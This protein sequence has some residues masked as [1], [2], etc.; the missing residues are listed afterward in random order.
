MTVRDYFE[1]ILIL[2]AVFVGF[3]IVI[4]VLV[5][6]IDYIEGV[7]NSRKANLYNR[8]CH[9]KVKLVANDFNQIWVNWQTCQINNT[10]SKNKGD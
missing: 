6:S 9:P 1:P 8:L 7:S 5:S 10:Y 4:T 3:C 2:V